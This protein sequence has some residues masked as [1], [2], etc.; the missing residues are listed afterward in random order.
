MSLVTGSEEAGQEL[1]RRHVARGRPSALDLSSRPVALV[2]G[3]AFRVD[4]SG[5]AGP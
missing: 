5:V 4:R 3:D 2:L 1:G